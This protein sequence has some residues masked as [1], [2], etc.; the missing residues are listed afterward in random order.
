MAAH[1]NHTQTFALKKIGSTQG[2]RCKDAV[3]TPNGDIVSAAIT[4][5]MLTYLQEAANLKTLDGD[6]SATRKRQLHEIGWHRGEPRSY[7]RFLLR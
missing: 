1:K 4:L 2:A 7:G 6:A 3:D 5:T